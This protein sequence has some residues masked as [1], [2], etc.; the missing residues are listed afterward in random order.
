MDRRSLPGWTTVLL[1]L[2]LTATGFVVWIGLQTA[3]WGALHLVGIS[4]D[5]WAMV[6]ALSTAVTVAALYFGTAWANP[7]PKGTLFIKLGI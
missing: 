6:E 5:Y 2:A 4:V 1:I 3:L 7:N